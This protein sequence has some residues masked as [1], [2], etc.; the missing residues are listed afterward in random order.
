V[1]NEE[2]ELSTARDMCACSVFELAN[3]AESSGATD[4]QTS[5]REFGTYRPG[6]ERKHTPKH[7]YKGTG[8]TSKK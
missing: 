4:H 3:E 2:T 1:F 6:P 8:P 7:V 5:R